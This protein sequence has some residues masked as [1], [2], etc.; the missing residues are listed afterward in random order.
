ML[1]RK[2]CL[3][4]TCSKA[5]QGK[6][7]AALL[8]LWMIYSIACN[9]S[10]G[11]GLVCLVRAV[12]QAGLSVPGAASLDTAAPGFR[13]GCAAGAGGTVHLPCRRPSSVPASLGKRERQ[14]G[15]ND[16]NRHLTFPVQRLCQHGETAWNRCCRI[17]CSGE[18]SEAEKPSFPFAGWRAFKKQN[19][20]NCICVSCTSFWLLHGKCG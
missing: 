3:L 18:L 5:T 20:V 12:L 19:K 17:S 13:Y 7:A 8:E 6:A 10:F 9:D 4:K 1:T 16:P 14:G 2:S 15:G 11:V